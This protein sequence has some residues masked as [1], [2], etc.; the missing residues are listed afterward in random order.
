MESKKVRVLIVDDSALI[1]SIL[2]QVLPLN[3]D[4]LEIVGMASNGQD[5]IRLNRELEP[6]LI[7]MDIDMPVM[8]GIESVKHIMSDRP[9]PIIVVSGSV[10]AE[11]SF[12]ALENGALE[13]M[14]KPEIT[15]F[16]DPGFY[17]PL[18]EK[19]IRLSQ[20]DVRK[21]G[22]PSEGEVVSVTRSSGERCAMIVLGV[23]TG[24]PAAVT[25]V[26]TRLPAD[27]PVGIALVQHIEAGF[28]AGYTKWLDPLCKLKVREATHGD[29]ISPGEIVISPDSK[30]ILF[31][32]GK[33]NLS[34][35]EEVLNQKPSVNVLFKSAAKAFGNRLI[36]VL[37]TGMGTDGA[38]GCRKIV[39]HGGYTIVQ[40]EATSTVFGMPK[41]AIE[42]GG[43]SVVLP[44]NEI[45]QALIDIVTK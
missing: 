18:Q 43:A 36:G 2:E 35:G 5:A 10:H 33:L 42:L 21:K 14:V 25:Q 32:N 4:I 38:E 26:L 34:D 28:G 30:H 7:T 45:S 27:F 8:N 12:Q 39:D 11:D 3:N 17:K 41:A 6:D 29:T 20:I 31:E 19:L 13:V 23:S 16:N 37:L 22:Q 40:N 1:R 9:A 24:G 44:L 15:D